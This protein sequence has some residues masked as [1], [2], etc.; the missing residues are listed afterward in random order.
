M[1]KRKRTRRSGRTF[2]GIGNAKFRIGQRVCVSEGSGIDS[3][4]CGVIVSPRE[5]VTDGRGIPRNIPGA[6]SEMDLSRERPVRLDNGRL[7]LMFKNRLRRS[8]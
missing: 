1:A 2:A 5:V 3:G 7:I 4:R 8:K 6:Y